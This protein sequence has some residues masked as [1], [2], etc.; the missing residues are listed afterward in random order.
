MRLDDFLGMICD[1]YPKRARKVL[2]Q[3]KGNYRNT[4]FN[5]PGLSSFWI[6]TTWEV[7]LT[8]SV[9]ANGYRSRYFLRK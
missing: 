2:L 4:S 1:L 8:G 6:K 5:I 7:L 3:V 9:L